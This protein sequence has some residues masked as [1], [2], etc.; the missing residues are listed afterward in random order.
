VWQ[1]DGLDQLSLVELPGIEPGSL[2][3]LL[4]FE[5]PI[6]Y[7]SFPFGPAH[8]LRFGF[9]VLTVSKPATRH[10]V[11]LGGEILQLLPDLRRF[12]SELLRRVGAAEKLAL[13]SG[14]RIKYRNI[15]GDLLWAFAAIS[16]SGSG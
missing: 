13:V 12:G 10:T 1:V 6:R 4:A 3:G 2:P 9:R 7:V 5:L 14:R 16:G 15:K 8:Y 11:L